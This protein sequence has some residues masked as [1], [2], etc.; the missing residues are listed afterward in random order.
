MKHLPLAVLPA[1]AYVIGAAVSAQSTALTI[2]LTGQSMLRSDLRM[3]KPAALPVIKSL[4]T[5]DVIFTNL[6]AT[7][8]LP[9]ETVSEGR[10]FLTPPEALDALRAMGFNLLA[11]ANNHAFDLKE[12]GIR[13]TIGELDRR[14][15]VHAGTGVNIA[16]AAAPAYLQTP[17]GT[18]ALVAS[19]SGLISAGGGAIPAHAGVNELRV[20][21]GDGKN[22]GT[23]DLPTAANTVNP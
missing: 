2:A 14:Q 21:A 8:A 17:K 6:E 20:E 15:I 22:N 23:E 11:L 5:G 3:T 16:A 9:G 18:I 10:G 12:S 7:V 13:N 1:A 4:L 19:A